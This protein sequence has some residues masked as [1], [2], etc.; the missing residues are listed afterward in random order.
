MA[1]SA[2][3][4]DYHANINVQMNYWPAEVCNLAECHRPLFDLIDSLR[5]AAAGRRRCT[6]ADGWTVHTI[7]NVFGFTSPG[8][9]RV[10]D[11]P[12]PG[13]GCAS[14]VG[15]HAISATGTLQVCPS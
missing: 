11:V 4:A 8:E 13:P 10:G 14:T 9:A 3:N 1:S 2:L 6:G 5:P 12:S 7:T 15:A